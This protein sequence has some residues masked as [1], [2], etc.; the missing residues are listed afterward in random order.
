MS[1]VKIEWRLKGFE[2]IRRLPAVKANLKSRADRIAA[3]SGEG[4]VAESG[5]GKSR[6]RA[7]VITGNIRAMNDNRKNNTILRNVDAGKGS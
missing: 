6:S 2:E 7:S 5:E 1:K 3:A 4:Y